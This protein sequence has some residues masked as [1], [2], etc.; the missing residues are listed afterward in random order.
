MSPTLLRPS[1]VRCAGSTGLARIAS[2]WA[3][4]AA[5][6]C[7]PIQRTN[8]GADHESLASLLPSLNVAEVT[9]LNV[10]RDSNPIV[11]AAQTIDVYS[12][13]PPLSDPVQLQ[14]ESL[15]QR[16]DEMVAAKQGEVESYT[17]NQ[18]A[19][20]ARSQHPSVQ[21]ASREIDVARIAVTTASAERNPNL[22]IDLDAPVHDRDSAAELT[23]RITFPFGRNRERHWQRRV[24][25]ARVVKAEADLQVAVRQATDAAIAA[26]LRSIYLHEQLALDVRSERLAGDRLAAIAQ[27]PV[28]DNPA[29]NLLDRMEARLEAVEATQRRFSTQRELAVTDALLASRMGLSASTPLLVRGSLDRVPLQT[30]TL[31]EV[32]QDAANTSEAIEA[33]LAS[34]N[35]SR[36]FH[37]LQKHISSSKEFGPR[38]QD[39]LGRGNDRIGVRLELDLDL[40]HTQQGPIAESAQ[41]IHQ[42]QDRLTLARHVWLE[43][44]TGIHRELASI[45]AEL[46]YYREDGFVEDQHALLD[47]ELA[48]RLITSAERIKIE[49]S[50]VGRQREQLQLRYLIA[51]LRSQLG[52]QPG[53]NEGENSFGH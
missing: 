24:A 29:N 2:T 51:V 44:I 35:E 41:V 16:T 40:Q 42:Q 43:E 22:V 17:L 12:D 33:A 38:Y 13:A 19:D 50:I 7:A 14:F 20:F 53:V 26:A 21:A 4:I 36:D 18:I 45:T 3:V 10:D 5:V 1:D 15:E 23:T 37:G 32:V 27:E 8:G 9:A 34:L 28:R 47:D 25:L 6:G 39:R 52:L 11:Q 49:Q 46:Q 48:R 31:D 30:P